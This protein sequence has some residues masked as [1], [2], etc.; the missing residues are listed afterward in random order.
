MF[1]P[2]GFCIDTKSTTVL[3]PIRLEFPYPR[4]TEGPGSNGTS[5][6]DPSWAVR[7]RG[8]FKILF[9]CWYTTKQRFIKYVILVVCVLKKTFFRHRY[10]PVTFEFNENPTITTPVIGKKFKDE[11]QDK[12]VYVALL[13]LSMLL[14]PDCMYTYRVPHEYI[15]TKNLCFFF[16]FY[17]FIYWLA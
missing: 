14:Q 5:G 11:L 13:D 10:L 1:S 16:F 17:F 3:W 12:V 7:L 2:L 4:C 6:G 8:R 9:S 15:P